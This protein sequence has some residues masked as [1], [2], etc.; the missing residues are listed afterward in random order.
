MS[1]G[2]CVAVVSLRRKMYTYLRNMLKTE[3][4][5]KGLQ[6]RHVFFCQLEMLGHW[7]YHSDSDS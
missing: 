3:T 4:S 1:A 5:D 7:F 6:Y 2:I